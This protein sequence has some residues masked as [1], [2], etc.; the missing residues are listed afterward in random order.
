VI[1]ANFLNYYISKVAPF[2]AAKGQ[3]SKKIYRG[4]Q[5]KLQG[6]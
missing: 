4:G 1:G 2:V 5:Q 3:K 6:G